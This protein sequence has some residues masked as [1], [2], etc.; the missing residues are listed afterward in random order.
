MGCGGPDVRSSCRE[1][2]FKTTSKLP[3]CGRAPRDEISGKLG[4][5]NRGQTSMRKLPIGVLERGFGAGL[6]QNAPPNA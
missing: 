2:N 3:A 6:A 5:T 1:K 4:Q